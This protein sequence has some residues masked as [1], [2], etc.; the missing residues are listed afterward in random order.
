MGQN[1]VYTILVK[2]PAM[3]FSAKELAQL[4]NLRVQTVLSNIKALEKDNEISIKLVK[5]KTNHNT[6]LIGY[7][8]KDNAFE[9]ICKEFTE[10]RSEKRFSHARPEYLQNFLI[11]TELRKL[12]EEMNN[13]R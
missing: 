11:L 1:D 2:N 8:P 4:T 5:G 10:Y 3:F 6:K 7:I 9:T 13:G 12:R